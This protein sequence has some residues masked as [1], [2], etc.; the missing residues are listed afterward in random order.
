MFAGSDEGINALDRNYLS[1]GASVC[2][3]IG[4]Q[5]YRLLG[6]SDVRLCDYQKRSMYV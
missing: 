3:I 5:W 6:L 2:A 1:G 4:H